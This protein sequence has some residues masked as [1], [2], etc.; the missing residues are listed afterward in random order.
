MSEKLVLGGVRDKCYY[1]WRT[2]TS[3]P[4]AS[5]ASEETKVINS[6]VSLATKPT[7]WITIGSSSA[8]SC[9][10]LHGVAYDA[11]SR[12]WMYVT[13]HVFSSNSSSPDDSSWLRRP[14]YSAA[15]GPKAYC[16]V[17]MAVVPPG[18]RL[19]LESRG[20]DGDGT[21]RQADVSR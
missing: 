4:A 11:L 12:H 6:S 5:S 13:S 17:C 14:P 2:R 18:K 9:G 20:H 3:P 15:I 1:L 19:I 10:E 7:V 8:I 16:S 21:V